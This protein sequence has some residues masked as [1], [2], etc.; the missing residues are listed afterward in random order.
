MLYKPP[1]KKRFALIAYPR[2]EK[3][4]LTARLSRNKV[5]A[6]QQISAGRIKY[7]PATKIIENAHVGTKKINADK[8]NRR[9][10]ESKSGRQTYKAV[11]ECLFKQ[12][13]GSSWEV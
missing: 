9:N 5:T 12:L 13:A 10:Y 8:T 11:K 2:T 6:L 7:V 4:T 1:L 3:V